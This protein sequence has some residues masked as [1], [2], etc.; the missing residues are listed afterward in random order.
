MRAPAKTKC[1]VGRSPTLAYSDARLRCDAASTRHRGTATANPH[2]GEV[3]CAR[4]RARAVVY[5]AGLLRRKILFSVH[6]RAAAGATGRRARLS[7]AI[8]R[9][10]N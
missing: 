7:V 9:L 10:L 2:L 5:C 6:V 4:S 1:T 3:P 8:N